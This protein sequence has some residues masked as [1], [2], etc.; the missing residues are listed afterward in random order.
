MAGRRMLGGER[1]HEGET[2][3]VTSPGDRLRAAGRRA[4]IAEI[5]TDRAGIG[6]SRLCRCGQ[7]LV[8]TPKTTQR[9]ANRIAL[10]AC[11][12]RYLAWHWATQ[13]PQSPRMRPLLRRPQFRG[14]R[15]CR[16][17]VRADSWTW[18]NSTGRVVCRCASRIVAR[19]PR[20]RMPEQGGSARAHRPSSTRRC[21]VTPELPSVAV[22]WV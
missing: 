6:R 7:Q 8:C 2:S 3:A 10:D 9:G 22:T 15:A 16:A 21:D 17:L 1:C 12:L 5:G 18:A 19:D 20:P 13:A 11:P 14:P 4:T